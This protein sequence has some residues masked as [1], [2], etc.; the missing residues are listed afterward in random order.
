MPRCLHVP[1]TLVQ[2]RRRLPPALTADHA[3]VVPAQ[4]D[5]PQRPLAQVV[6][7]GQVALLQVAAPTPPSC[8]RHNRS[9]GPA[10]TWATPADFCSSSH[11]FNSARTGLGLPLPPQLAVALPA[12]AAA[13]VLG[14]VRRR[15]QRRQVTLDGV[16]P[17]DPRH[18]VWRR[19]SPPSAAATNLRRACAQQQTCFTRSSPYSPSYWARASACR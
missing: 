13:P 19:S 11:R 2:H 10:P 3:P 16:Q 17:A 12:A 7:D 9:P 8:S 14:V 6:V 18:A 1:T 4:G 5:G 15:Q